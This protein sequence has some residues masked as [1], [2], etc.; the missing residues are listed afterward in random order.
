M[1]PI[2][3]KVIHSKNK[4]KL[5]H[6]YAFRGYCYAEIGIQI[7]EDMN[8]SYYTAYDNSSCSMSLI[9][10]LLLTRFYLKI[11]LQQMNTL[12]NVR[13]ISMNYHTINQFVHINMFIKVTDETND[14]VIVHMCKEFYVINNLKVNILIG[15]DILKMKDIDLKFSINEI[16]FINY[17]DVTASM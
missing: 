3:P 11:E 12:I 9:D 15:T 4:L 13:E 16:I 8:R 1:A 14:T 7:T 17:K 2:K 6:G 10:R 5:Q